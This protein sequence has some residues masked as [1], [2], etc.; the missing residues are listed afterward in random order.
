MAMKPERFD[1]GPSPRESMSAGTISKRQFPT[2]D[3]GRTPATWLLPALGST[4]GNKYLIALTAWALTG[5]VLVHMSGNLLIF[6]GRDALNSYALF[7]KD[8]GALLW[9]ARGGLLAVFVLHIWLTVRLKLRNR[10]AR[11]VPYAY[12]QTIQASW[13]SRHM[14]LAGL[15]ILAFVVFHLMHYTFGLV[16]AT[17]PSGV[18]FL[19]LHDPAQRHDVYAMT[20]YGFRNVG[21]SIAY[22]IAQLFLGLHLS[23]GISSTFQSL[24][25]AH[26]R[27]WPTIRKIG[28]ALA[29][30]I[31][32]GNVSMPL[33]VLF[34]LAG[35]DVP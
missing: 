27:Y 17:S 32:I 12:E 21:V 31:V 11:P 7:L 19:R 5:F 16:A 29:A 33:A 3:D 4:V 35:T 13:A 2:N 15:V 20:I 18:N 8:R 30:V 1:F 14:L 6:K 25:I 23:H 34:R 10:A 9:V 28:L 26:P 22:I 24:G